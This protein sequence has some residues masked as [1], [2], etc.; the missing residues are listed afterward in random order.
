MPNRNLLLEAMKA[1]ADVVFDPHGAETAPFTAE[2][3]VLLGG[4][5]TVP[6]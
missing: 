5:P 1:G 4:V 2:V 6:G 3:E